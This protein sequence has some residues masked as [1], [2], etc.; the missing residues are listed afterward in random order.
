MNK[1]SKLLYNICD[2]GSNV[3]YKH[4]WLYWLLSFTWG[5]IGTVLGFVM[6]MCVHMVGGEIGFYHK[7]MMI[8]FGDNWGGLECGI[9][10]ICDKTASNYCKNHE[11]GHNYQNAILGPFAIILS[12]IPSIIR[13]HYRNIQEKKGKKLTTA[14]DDIWFEKSASDI[15]N[16]LYK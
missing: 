9:G 10:F 5:I 15:G 3:L 12:Y 8:T 7:H 14:Y 16:K 4:K 11:C 1:V 13:Y 2:K 6:M